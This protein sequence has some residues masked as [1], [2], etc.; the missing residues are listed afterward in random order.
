MTFPW[1]KFN[2]TQDDFK[3][4]HRAYYIDYDDGLYG[5]VYVNQELEGQP[6]YDAAKHRSMQH[7]INYY[8]KCVETTSIQHNQIL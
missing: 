2:N 3:D 1:L 4:L 6:W 7:N 8:A 5:S